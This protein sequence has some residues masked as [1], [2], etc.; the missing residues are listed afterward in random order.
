MATMKACVRHKYGN[1]EQIQIEKVQRPVPGASQV[2]VKVMA[3][4]VNRTDC[5]NLTGKP[6]IMHLM[7]GLIK[8]RRNSIGTDFSGIIVEK[9]RDV[10]VVE[11][12]DRVFGFVDMG[13]SSQAEYLLID[14][15]DVYR[16][17]DGINFAVAAASL[18]GAHYAY[19]FVHKVNIS[20]GQS[21]LINGATGAIGSALLQF[22]REKDVHITATCKTAQVNIISELGADQVVDY[23]KDDFTKTGQQYDFIF[24][25]VGKSTFGKCK[26][27]LKPKGV[28]ISSELGPRSEN[29]FYAV[30]SSFFGKKKLIFPYPYPQ[31]KTIPYICQRLLAKT[32]SPL[33]DRDYVFEDIAKAYAYVLKGEKI[34]NVLVSI[35]DPN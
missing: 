34:G 2:L 18:E 26:R 1:F 4:T 10:N 22:V 27:L 30:Y 20:A 8:P 19:T 29:L 15:K 13:I 25:A 6:F 21:V 17:P 9:G 33:I 16:I 24:D 5:A 14:A 28:Y 7:L 23:T 31:R 32:F 35:G 3:T 11:L 12:D